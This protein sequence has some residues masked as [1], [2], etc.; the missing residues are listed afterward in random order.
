ML[1]FTLYRNAPLYLIRDFLPCT[2]IV[3]LSWINFWINFRSTPARTALG[4]TTVLTIV[5]MTN[6]VRKNSPSSSDLFRSIDYYMLA[7]NMFVFAA[8]FEG[9]LVGMM[10]PNEKHVKDTFKNTVQKIIENTKKLKKVGMVR[11]FGLS[12]TL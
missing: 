11:Y 9:A 8:L 1:R 7:C 4:I 2:L 6:N 5:T 12:R 10:A 3:M